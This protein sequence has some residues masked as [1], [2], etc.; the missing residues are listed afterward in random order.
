MSG[1]GVSYTGEWGGLDGH[2]VAQDD[3]RTEPVSGWQLR[4]VENDEHY[5]SGF[6]AGGE[7]SRCAVC[8]IGPQ[9]HHSC[10]RVLLLDGLA[11]E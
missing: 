5:V 2:S 4:E 3:P 10:A 6:G 1:R 7:S 9:L 11:D 8:S